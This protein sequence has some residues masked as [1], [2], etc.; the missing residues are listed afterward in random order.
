MA[1]TEDVSTPVPATG[2]GTGNITTASFSPPANSLLVALVGGGW[3]TTALGATITDSAGGTWTVGATATGTNASDGGLAK[4]FYRYL[5]SA[6]GAMTVTAAYTNLSGGR[7]LAVRVVNGAASSQT[8]ASGSAVHNPAS[9]S[10][11]VSVTTTVT[12]SVVYGITDNAATA[13][14]CTFNAGTTVLTSGDFNDTTDSVRLTAWSA[15]SPTGTPGATTFGGTY[16]TATVTNEAAFEILPL[17]STIFSGAATLSGVATLSASGTVAGPP[18]VTMASVATLSVIPFMPPPP[19]FPTVPR[20]IIVELFVNGGWV[21]I[22]D[23]VYVRNSLVIKRGRADGQSRSAPSSCQLTI[24][25]RSGNY[26]PRNPMGLYYGSLG[27][28]T[29]IRVSVE[30]ASDTFTRTVSSGWGTSDSGVTYTTESIGSPTLASN[31]NVDG[32]RGTFSLPGANKTRTC[33]LNGISLTDADVS[34][35]ATLP[36]NL[37]T[38][39]GIMHFVQLRRQSVTDYVRAWAQI[40]TD[41]SVLAGVTHADATILVSQVTVPGL[42]FSAAVGLNIRGQVEGQ[43]WRI[44]VWPGTSPEPYAWTVTGNSTY[45]MDPGSIAVSTWVRSGNTNTIPI[46][47]SIDNLHVRVPRFCGEV[48]SWP[49]RW[50]LSG[51]DVYVQVEAA[52]LKRRLSQGNHPMQSALYRYHKRLATPPVAY[53]PGEDPP[54]SPQQIAP[55]IGTY[56]MTPDNAG[57]I[58]LAKYSDVQSSAPIFQIGAGAFSTSTGSATPITIGPS[59][60]GFVSS[61]ANGVTMIRAL[62]NIPK[63]TVDESQFPPPFSASIL[64]LSCTGTVNSISVD[65]YAGGFLSAIFGNVVFD[66]GPI[67]YHDVRGT[68]QVLQLQLTE[69]G[70]NTAWDLVQLYAGNTTGL[71]FGTT[72]TGTTVGNVYNVAVN[73]SRTL[74]GCAFGHISHRIENASISEIVQPLNGYSGETAGT[75][76]ARLCTEEVVSYSWRGSLVDTEPVGG[77][78]AG[79]TNSTTGQNLRLFVPSVSQTLLD[80]LYECED[81]DLGILYEARG[82]FGLEYR[83]RRDLYSQTPTLTLDYSLGQVAPPL[84]PVDDDQLTRNN[85]TISR[86]NGLSAEAELLAGPLSTLDPSEGGVGDYQAQYT[87]NVASDDQL[88]DIAT[89]LLS[90]GT[91]D[92]ARYPTVTVDLANPRFVTASLESAAFAVNMGDLIAIVNPKTGVT[93]DTIKQIVQGYTETLNVFQHEITFNTA[94]ETPYRLAQV[95]ATPAFKVD[96][97]TATLTFDYSATANSLFIDNVNEPWT[98]DPTQMPIP[99]TVAGELMNVTAISGTSSPQTFTVTRSI[100]GVIKSQ[101]AGTTVQIAR[102]QRPFIAF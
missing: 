51:E 5:S 4:V 1:I 64:F 57:V 101:S 92:E 78:G 50:D 8:G 16:A 74:V 70:G 46:V 24:D 36:F 49:Q 98:T 73:G 102:P 100:N 39:A 67:A 7:F 31:W 22:S 35:F 54:N 44:K 11:T 60:S 72:I 61:Y 37:P 95:S 38:G 80:L 87:V 23:D 55:A 97:A 84:E 40:Q 79:S 45:R 63:D 42:T 30:L 47:S 96:A 91:D 25:N 90:L 14:A 21:D 18:K 29:P 65:Y 52:G 28:N 3:S 71:H 93:F 85:I 62:V 58:D 26:S 66:S 13:T 68:P 2:T 27:R 41:G 59:I 34:C 6:P 33:I 94:P 43:T 99:I 19:A 82:D 53:W 81:A 88:A 9:T 15:T 48:S 86:T 75:R 12:G 89:F 20:V 56:P 77:Q 17:I 76:F 10:A 69:S 32:S 83:T